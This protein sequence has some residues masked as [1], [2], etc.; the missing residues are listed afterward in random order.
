MWPFS[1][2]KLA[3]PARRI[4]CRAERADAGAGAP[5]CQ[6]PPARRPLSCRVGK[7]ALW[8]GLLLG[9]RARFLAAPGVWV[10]AVGYAGGS[11]P[12][13]TYEEV[14]SGRTGH[15]EAV[16]VV[17][18][19]RSTL[20]SVAEI[21]LERRPYP[22]HAPGQRLGTQYRS[23]IYTFSPEQRR[24]A[25]AAR[26]AYQQRLERRQYGASPPKSPM[27][28]HFISPRITTSNIWRKIRA[29]IA[30]SAAP[31]CLARSRPRSLQ[32]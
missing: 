18:D 13:P 26:D 32:E 25:E 1:R 17:Y 3:F 12:N 2:D 27:P 31:G 4:V 20:R 9:C 19:P 22:G 23:A 10:T 8:P 6:R 16:L 29:A 14:C 28:P 21:V 5:F 7:G 30:V 24:A 15:T 11:T